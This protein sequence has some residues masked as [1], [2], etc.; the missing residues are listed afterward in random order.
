M[1]FLEVCYILFVFLVHSVKTAKFYSHNFSTLWG[2]AQK[3]TKIV[4]TL[5]ISSATIVINNQ[6]CP[7]HKSGTGKITGE[8]LQKK[9]KRMEI[10]FRE[11]DAVHFSLSLFLI[12]GGKIIVFED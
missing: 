5:L 6:L 11:N 4:P 1:I 3:I 12:C 9:K 7:T 10:F 8:N 2:S